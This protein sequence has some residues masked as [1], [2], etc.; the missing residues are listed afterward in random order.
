MAQVSDARPV[1]R[2]SRIDGSIRVPGDKSISHR[3][4][5]LASLA[6]GPSVI[7]GYAPGADC[8]ATLACLRAFGVRI[9]R[10]GPTVR[11]EGRGLRG[12]QQA[13]GAVDA[14]NSGTSMRL[15]AGL[16]AAHPFRTVLTGDA[17]LSRR[18]MRRVI[19][20]LTRMGAR[21]DAVDGRPPLT[22][23]GANLHAITHVPEVPSAQVKSAVLLAGLHASGR[24][25]VDEPAPTRDHTERALEAFGAH[26]D[27]AGLAVS[28]DGGQR[29]TGCELTVPGDLSSAVF[30]LA[31]AAACPGS[32]LRI[33]GVGLNPSRTAVL[34]VL[35]RAGASIEVAPGADHGEPMGS[36]TLRAGEA[37][38]VLEILPEDVPGIIDEIPAL[39]AMAAISRGGALTVRGAGELRVKESDRI[40]MLARGFGAI[41]IHVEEFPDG[42]RLQG[43]PPRG[44]IADAAGDHRLAMAFAIAGTAARDPVTIEGAGA[45]AVSYP[46]FFDELDRLADGDHR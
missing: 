2:V 6:D 18:P 35:R 25:T 27:R 44:G 14:A 28:V 17:S 1:P 16:A 10:E 46:G 31:L 38:V 45:V 32:V 33:D 23:T 39:A 41:G 43:G 13:A 12:W 36:I 22:I 42:F 37:P 7:R 15:L 24:T 3:F 34:D 40:T 8:A 21:I 20:P 11:V 5:M 9:A 30:W 26:V 4:A 19:D 29:L